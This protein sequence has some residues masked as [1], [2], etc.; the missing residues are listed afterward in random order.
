M[1][2]L[3][4]G[5][6]GGQAEV[7][8]L[9]YSKMTTLESAL[10]GIFSAMITFTIGTTWIGYERGGREMNLV[11]RWFFETVYQYTNSWFIS[12]VAWIPLGVGAI[13]LAAKLVDRDVRKSFN[14]PHTLRTGFIIMIFW[15]L[16]S[17]LHQARIFKLPNNTFTFIW[18]AG[19]AVIY[20][21]FE[22]ISW[23]MSQ[24][25]V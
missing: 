18:A 7:F 12:I 23:K 14:Y 17:V 11:A 4:F 20:L 9:I 8:G 10:F 3:S 5:G 21:L 24:K 13:F 2:R 16:P 15:L 6:F 25:K 19:G 1:S 22:I